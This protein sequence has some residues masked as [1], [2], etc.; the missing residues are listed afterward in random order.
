MENLLPNLISNNQNEYVANRFIC[1]G[2]RLIS[3]ILEMAD[4]L[5][6]EGYPLIIGIEKAS[7]HFLY[8][9]F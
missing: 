5:N 9:I 7:D 2:D 6:M 8:L 4:S 3:N 1:E